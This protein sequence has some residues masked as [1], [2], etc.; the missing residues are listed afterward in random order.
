LA[1]VANTRKGCGVS[2]MENQMAWHYLPM[3]DEQYQQ[4]V[5]EVVECG[6]LSATV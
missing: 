1:I 3:S 6:K 4:A 2:F 5:R